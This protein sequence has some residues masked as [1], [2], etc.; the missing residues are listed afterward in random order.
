MD[1]PFFMS[2]KNAVII[3]ASF[4]NPEELPTID[5]HLP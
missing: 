2:L 5:L 3:S 4:I 1:Y